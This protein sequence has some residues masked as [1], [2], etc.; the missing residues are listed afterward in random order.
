MSRTFTLKTILSLFSSPGQQLGQS[1]ALHLRVQHP[2]R[3]TPRSKELSPAHL[4]LPAAPLCREGRGWAA[5]PS[6]QE[7]GQSQTGH[8][9]E[10]P[11]RQARRRRTRP[12]PTSPLP[13][14]A[15]PGLPG[16]R[17]QP[18][19]LRPHGDVDLRG[20]HG[21]QPGTLKHRQLVPSPLADRLAGP[22]RTLSKAF[23]TNN[24]F[25][26]LWPSQRHGGGRQVLGTGGSAWGRR[27]R[28]ETVRQRE[29]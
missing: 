23:G 6:G 20:G 19:P 8:P 18:G 17:A 14:G 24:L 4:L 3:P 13:L 25:C 9:R 10:G 5:Q 29:G 11:R 1:G 2:H 22:Q 28:R 15:V 7:A 16:G 27:G 26:R 21:L 12:V